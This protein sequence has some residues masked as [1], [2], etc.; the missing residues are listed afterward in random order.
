MESIAFIIS[1]NIIYSEFM[2]VL[3][4]K[5]MVGFLWTFGGRPQSFKTKPYACFKQCH[6][7]IQVICRKLADL[8]GIDV[9]LLHLFCGSLQTTAIRAPGP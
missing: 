9:T 4:G 6:F 7:L 8:Q 1:I 5:M 2:S 3:L